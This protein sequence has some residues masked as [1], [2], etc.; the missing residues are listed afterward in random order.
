VQGKLT[1]RLNN[2]ILNNR[3][4][5]IDYEVHHIDDADLLVIAYGFTARSALFAIEELRREGKKIGLL[6]LKTLWPFA[7]KMVKDIG[8]RIKKIFVPEMNRGQIAGEVMKYVCGD[9]VSYGQ[10]NGEVIHPETI[11]EQIRRLG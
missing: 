7:D 2:K 8:A 5:I 6:R 3:D 10:T 1:S 4:K 9:V 11:V